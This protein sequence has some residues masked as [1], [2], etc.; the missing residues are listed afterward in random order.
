MRGKMITAD[1]EKWIL[2]KAYVPEHI[3]SLMV[4]IS[5][6]QPFLSNGY[7]F[8]VGDN[9][10]ILV[11]YPLD[12]E[13]SPKSFA[14]AFAYVT[15]GYPSRYWWIIAPSLPEELL[16]SCGE[17][18]SDAYYRL[19]FEDFEDKDRLRRVAERATSR[20]MVEVT[21][22]MTPEHEDLISEFIEKE[23][24][25]SLIR[26]FY[27][28]M[29]DYVLRS[30]TS[31]VLNARDFN[32]LL[33][34]FYV[35]DLAANDFATY[36]VGCHS[37]ERYVSHASD[38]LF[39]EMVNMTREYGKEYINLGL[40]VNPGIRRFKEKWGGKPSLPYEFCEYRSG[41]P[42]ITSTIDSLISRL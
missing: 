34:A 17:R 38:L 32:G 21:R 10:G 42:N 6:G 9:W 20:L 36:V 25:G 2:K 31:L 24:P 19:T 29:P 40:G 8:Y 41:I 15:S 7:L 30:E 33:S 22:G 26:E 27:R 5:K 39:F 28:A 14:G 37:K 16:S 35:L 11:G 4:I 18:Q 1:E 3:V 13:F 12:S 23:N